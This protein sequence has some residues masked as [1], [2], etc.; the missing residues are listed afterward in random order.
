MS[1][2]PNNA[3]V[4]LCGSNISLDLSACACYLAF[5]FNFDRGK[6]S[7]RGL[8]AARNVVWVPV[9]LGAWVGKV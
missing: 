8:V 3:P 6:G 9:A 5:S 4:F 1:R 2:E 7:T